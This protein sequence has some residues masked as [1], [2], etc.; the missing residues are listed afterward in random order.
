M[1]FTILERLKNIV[2]NPER[3]KD[4]RVAVDVHWLKGGLYTWGSQYT[5]L[6]TLLVNPMTTLVLHVY[7]CHLSSVRREYKAG[8]ST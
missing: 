3:V 1:T 8:E 2:Y 6:V 5:D 4:A 7:I